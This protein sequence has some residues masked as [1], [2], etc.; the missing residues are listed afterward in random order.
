MLVTRIE[1]HTYVV[2]VFCRE[3]LLTA[4]GNGK[5]NTT[6]SACPNRFDCIRLLAIEVVS[7]FVII[8]MFHLD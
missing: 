2:A 4:S 6:A 1:L 5:R 7:V 8:N 3:V